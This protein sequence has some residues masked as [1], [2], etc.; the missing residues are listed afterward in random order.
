MSMLMP[1][2][3]MLREVRTCLVKKSSFASRL[4]VG[5]PLWFG[6]KDAPMP[7]P[8]TASCTARNAGTM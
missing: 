8:N 5:M 3:R 7:T 4:T 1:Q 2:P 6:A